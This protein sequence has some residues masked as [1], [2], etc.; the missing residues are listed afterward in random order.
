MPIYEYACSH[1]DTTFERR[2]SFHEEPVSTCPSCGGAVRRVYQAVGIIFKGPGFYIT[3]S[4]PRPKE[5]G[6]TGSANGS[7]SAASASTTEAAS[8]GSKSDAA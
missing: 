4:R 5:E 2:Q 7:S 6:G 1:C 8:A 3:D